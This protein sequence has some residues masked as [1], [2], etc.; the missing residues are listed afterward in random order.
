MIP[1]CRM[2]GEEFERGST[3]ER[4]HSC[5]RCLNNDLS[6]PDIQQPTA[7]SALPSDRAPLAVA[8]GA[9]YL[10][11]VICMD[12]KRFVG[13]SPGYTQPNQVSHGLC[14]QCYGVRKEEL[15][16]LRK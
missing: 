16:Q 12:C 4:Q 7:P 3:P 15:D 6:Y 14:P 13:W 2:C 5:Q 1:I 9:P 8:P 11:Q 10:A